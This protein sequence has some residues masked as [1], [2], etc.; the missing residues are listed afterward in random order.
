MGAFNTPATETPALRMTDAA[1]PVTP[2]HVVEHAPAEEVEIMEPREAPV[3]R[4]TKKHKAME[5]VVYE[6]DSEYGM[7]FGASGT[8]LAASINM[9]HDGQC[10]TVEMMEDDRVHAIKVQKGGRAYTKIQ[11]K[12][13]GGRIVKVRKGKKSKK[14]RKKH[15]K[16]GKKRR[17]H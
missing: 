17:H 14:K 16:K 13:A 8:S 3:H 10:E 12:C 6:E 9:F 7:G 11:R 5:M 2:A 15:K 4:R 1:P